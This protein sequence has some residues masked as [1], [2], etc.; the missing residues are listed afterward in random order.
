MLIPSSSTGQ[1]PAPTDKDFIWSCEDS[2]TSATTQ[3][4][5][6]TSTAIHH[7]LF[8]PCEQP[9]HCLI[10]RQV[11][12]SHYQMELH[13]CMLSLVHLLSSPIWNCLSHL[14]YTSKFLFSFCIYLVCCCLSQSSPGYFSNYRSQCGIQ[15]CV[16][17]RQLDCRDGMY[18]I[19]FNQKNSFR[20][21]RFFHLVHSL[22]ENIIMCSYIRAP[23]SKHHKE[24]V[25]QWGMQ[26][27][28]PDSEA[29]A[30]TCC[31]Y[32]QDQK[33]S[34]LL[35]WQT[36][37]GQAETLHLLS[38]VGGSS[39]QTRAGCDDLGSHSSLDLMRKRGHVY[40]CINFPQT[41]EWPPCCW[42]GG[43]T[44][45]I[46]QEHW[47]ASSCFYEQQGTGLNKLIGPSSHQAFQTYKTHC[48]VEYYLH[49]AGFPLCLV[50]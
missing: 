22:V 14:I 1:L 25:R 34:C 36:C 43:Y 32:E 33:H 3:S 28:L 4:Q 17:T 37:T 50:P 20:R 21:K 45:Y 27:Y 48:F 26:D 19:F 29:W 40:L 47:G 24:T 10:F 15:C 49:C 9:W 39:P 30:L 42:K 2:P 41:A 35:C 44:H 13:L 46:E 38:T 7:L 16:R 23:C 12:G 8:H 6:C 18:I 11:R 31:N 5:L